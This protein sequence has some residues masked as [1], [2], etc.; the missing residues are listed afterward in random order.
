MSSGTCARTTVVVGGDGR[1]TGATRLK[2]MVSSSSITFMETDIVRSSTESWYF[3]NA[4]P[5][6][7]IFWYKLSSKARIT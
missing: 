7:V 1:R 6:G 4:P 2:A 5:S 3:S